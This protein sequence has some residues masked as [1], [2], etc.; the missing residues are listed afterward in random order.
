MRDT[1]RGLSLARFSLDAADLESGGGGEGESPDAMSPGGSE[2]RSGDRRSPPS[3]RHSFSDM[4]TPH[5]K[6]LH[7]RTRQE[8]PG[9][10]GFAMRLRSFRRALFEDWDL[11]FSALRQLGGA[12]AAGGSVQV[13]GVLGLPMP[14]MGEWYP[15]GQQQQQDPRASVSPTPQPPQ[16]GTSGGASQSHH[17]QQQQQNGAGAASSKQHQQRMSLD[18]S[19]AGAKTKAKS[20][21][22]RNTTTSEMLPE[23]RLEVE[24]QG[25]QVS[26]EQ[27]NAEVVIAVVPPS[28]TKA[29]GL[30]SERR[31]P[32]SPLV[33]DAIES[34]SSPS[35]EGAHEPMHGASAEP[36]PPP[37][38]PEPR[39]PMKPKPKLK[40]AAQ[41]LT[42]DPPPRLGTPQQKVAGAA[43]AGA[44]SLGPSD[45]MPVPHRQPPPPPVPHGSAAKPKAPQ[46]PAPSAAEPLAALRQQQSPASPAEPVT[47]RPL[48]ELQVE[49]DQSSPDDSREESD[50]TT[51]LTEGVVP[52][53]SCSSSSRK[54]LGAGS[55]W[56]RALSGRMGGGD[57]EGEEDPLSSGPVSGPTPGSYSV[58]SAGK[59]KSGGRS[60]K[61]GEHEELPGSSG[62]EESPPR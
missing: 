52:G 53:G 30:P 57:A 37:P 17:Q 6:S 51:P 18:T 40:P 38:A 23:V 16:G 14:I 7:A 31:S 13:P 45:S 27:Q 9:G 62:D 19:S 35:E 60:H 20:P 61:K 55:S 12:P 32:T 3:K 1:R 11:D 26:E 2:G 42:A 44:A 47:L 39:S 28:L 25:V 8:A 50:V 4:S 24:L 15:A 48:A 29:S 49:H 36:P 10:E 33:E 46:S 34:D 43:A 58:R 54:H 41:P 21:L 5:E 59:Q 22:R 56:R